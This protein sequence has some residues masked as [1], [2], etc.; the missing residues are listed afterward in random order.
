MRCAG[1]GKTYGAAVA[2]RAVDLELAKGTI[3]GLVGRNGAGKTTLLRILAR[4]LAPSSGSVVHAPGL[5]IGLALDRD[6]ALYGDMP[7]ESYLRCMG[8]LGAVRGRDPGPSE[9][10]SWLDLTQRRRQE[11]RTLSRGYRQRVLLAQALLGAPELLLL[12]E[13][14]NSLD[15]VQIAEVSQLLRTIPW[16]PAMLVSSHV[17]AQVVDVVDDI[18]A[19]A[20]GTL[21]A[22]GPLAEFFGPHDAGQRTAVAVAVAGA[23]NAVRRALR[24]FEVDDLVT[25]GGVTRA[26]V[27]AP[28]DAPDI[29]TDTLA[30][31]VVTC[32]AES[33]L[34]IVEVNPR[35][36]AEFV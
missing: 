30:V 24:G 8:K 19:M 1:L 16:A 21:I 12:D 27:G 22:R 17:V 15:P 20:A 35:R 4:A 2:L 10:M 23:E 13:P 11:I 14:L 26:L 5:R 28:R 6:V 36:L 7:V 33:G 9:V 25:R 3:T 32:L 34:A 29:P 18:V 31:Q